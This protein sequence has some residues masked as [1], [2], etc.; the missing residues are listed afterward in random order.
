MHLSTTSIQ[1][2]I[3][4][5]V[6]LLTHAAMIDKLKVFLNIFDLTHLVHTCIVFKF[7]FLSVL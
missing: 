4:V 2:A 5:Y 6:N 1:E 7:L 3:H